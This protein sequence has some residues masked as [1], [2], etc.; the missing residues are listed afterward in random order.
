[1]LLYLDMC[2]MKRP[3][4][5]QSHPR[6]RLESEAVLGLL[7]A[8]S[9]SLRFVRSAALW[10]ENEQNPLPT[11]A[12][13]VRR[14]LGNPHPIPEAAAVVSRAGDLTKLGLKRFDALHVAS[15]EAVSA[16]A[17][18][19]CD[20]RLMAAARRAGPLINV[21]ILGVVEL[22]AEILS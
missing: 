20:D 7:A 11:R 22:A 12:A 13:R 18:A 16:D 15:A 14:W 21:R 5:D 19:T 17:L 2:C 9:D 1:M 8:E 10:L 6:I 3:F 4:D